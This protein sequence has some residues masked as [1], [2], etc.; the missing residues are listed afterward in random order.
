MSPVELAA[1]ARARSHEWPTVSRC[2]VHFDREP[3]PKG[4]AGPAVKSDSAGGEHYHLFFVT[5]ADK[6]QGFQV[7]VIASDTEAMERTRDVLAR[8]PYAVAIE[9]WKRGVLVRRIDRWHCC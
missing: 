8:H 9:V 5:T 4:E 2:Y 3:T 7:F 1:F 6:L